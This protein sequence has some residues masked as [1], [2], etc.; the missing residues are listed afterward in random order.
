MREL[1]EAD[2]PIVREE[3]G[4][5]EAIRYYEER[6]EPFKVEILQGLPPDVRRVSF[7]RQG[8]F[9]DLCRGPHVPSTGHLRAFKLPSN[10]RAYRRGV[11]HRPTPPR[12]YRTGQ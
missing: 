2:Y 9:V 5:D 10:S 7:Y 3:M 12:F 8:D 1:A 6:G 11:A 4:R